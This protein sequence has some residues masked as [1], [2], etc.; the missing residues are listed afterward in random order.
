MW[1][2]FKQK[3]ILDVTRGKSYLTVSEMTSCSYKGLED[4]FTILTKT[5]KWLQSYNRP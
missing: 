5:N 1:H 3:I 4:L 2:T